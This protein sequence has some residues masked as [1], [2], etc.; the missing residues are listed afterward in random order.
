VRERYGFER[1]M[2][3]LGLAESAYV[4]E[5][6]QDTVKD[7][8]QVLLPL[9]QKNFSK[10]KITYG[11]VGTAIKFRTVAEKDFEAE[12]VKEAERLAENILPLQLK[13]APELVGKQLAGFYKTLAEPLPARLRTID[14]STQL[15][16]DEKAAVSSWAKVMTI[17]NAKREAANT[18]AF[19]STLAKEIV[20]REIQI[21]AGTVSHEMA[22]AYASQA[23]H[24]LMHMMKMR[25]MKDS[26][27]LDEGMA[28]NIER[29]I[30][31]DWW[32][33]QPSKTTIPLPGYDSTYTNRAKEFLK[34]LGNDLAYE[35]Y[36]GGWIDFTSN[37][38]PEDTLIMGKS[39]KKWK[40]P[41][42]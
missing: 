33:K 24:D 29:I 16:R 15:T 11:T 26:D 22:H 4:Y 20:F 12:V 9:F 1:E 35:A 30:V 8:M 19:Y 13:F 23:W 42:R 36:F 32:A 18:G 14:A 10:N 28:T 7:L 37:A 25:G 34:A 39:E 27:K 31:N 17:A 5:A 40:W 6:P 2:V 41:W 21:G 38:K 3:H